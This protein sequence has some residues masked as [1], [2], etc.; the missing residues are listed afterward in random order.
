[1]ESIV[2][3]DGQ[4]VIPL[5][6]YVAKVLKNYFNSMDGSIIPRGLYDVMMSEIE[7]SLFE[8]TLLYTRGNQSEAAKVLG[9]NRGTLHKKLVQYGMTSR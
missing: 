4:G 6:E 8:A 2:T 1:M 7:Q 9:I 5:R 3:T